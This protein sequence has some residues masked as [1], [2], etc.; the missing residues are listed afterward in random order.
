MNEI[1]ENNFQEVVNSV[2]QEV[3]SIN[4]TNIESFTKE[5][6]DYLID[7]II[8]KGYILNSKS[9]NYLRGNIKVVISSLRKNLDNIEYASK[10]VKNSEEIFNYFREN[11]L[12]YFKYILKKKKISEVIDYR[13]FNLCLDSL[14]NYRNDDK[15]FQTRVNQLVIN[16]V[17]TYPKVSTFKGIFDSIARNRWKEFRLEFAIDFENIFG[18]ICS[19]LRDTSN[20]K[21]A[22]NKMNFLE[23]MERILKDKY[24]LLYDDMKKYFNIY[25]SD[26]NIDRLKPYQ[27]EISKLSALYVAIA[28]EDFVK[29]EI[30]DYYYLIKQ[31]FKLK[32]D[33][34]L[35]K[36]QI[37]EKKRWEKIRNLYEDDMSFKEYLNSIVNKYNIY[38]SNEILNNLINEFINNKLTNLEDIIS[39]P[40]GYYD[41]IRYNK[42]KKLI[43]RLNRGYIKYDDQEVINYQDLIKFNKKYEYIGK[44][45]SEKDIEVYEEYQKKIKVFDNI[46]KEITHYID[47]LGYDNNYEEILDELSKKFPFTDEYF[48]F[49]SKTLNLF[50]LNTLYDSLLFNTCNFNQ[51]SFINDDDYSLLSEIFINNG[52]IWLLMFLS[53]S[54]QPITNDFNGNAVLNYINNIP[55]IY[56]LVL[57]T[58]YSNST[59]NDFSKL[60][61]IVEFIT[62]QDIAILGY[63][64]VQV[65]CKSTDY[66]DGDIKRIMESAVYLA[67]EK[68]KRTKLTVPFINGE[69]LDYKYSLYD[70][71]ENDEFI[72]GPLTDSCLKVCGNDHD[73]LTYCCLNKNGFMV[74]ITDREGNFIGRAAGVRNG[75]S[76]FFNQLRTIYDEGISYEGLNDSEK[77]SIIETFKKIC[78]DL[79]KNSYEC[80]NDIVKIEHVFVTRSFCLSKYP[81]N[82]SKEVIKKIGCNPI[83]NS[84]CDWQF[85]INNTK[86][87]EYA[88]RDNFIETDYGNYPVIC[89][90][91]IKDISNIDASDIKFMDVDAVYE[92]IRN[93]VIVTRVNEEVINKI[94]KIHGINTY[95]S[96]REF[97]YL[98]IPNESMVIMGDNWYIVFNNKIIDECVLNFDEKAIK[99]FNKIKEELSKNDIKKLIRS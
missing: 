74:K 15:K 79:I 20:F 11:N 30:E 70:F 2:L 29:S 34:P 71:L 51:D 39:A 8:S 65:L 23:H 22:L 26:N 68:V 85:F 76:I 4:Y 82:L 42:V 7:L 5:E 66:T 52:I 46:K 1:I 67:S 21:R 17:I 48:T 62:K 25:H 83:D 24:N 92:R 94:N 87:L 40:I 99:E 61:D 43:N 3:N 56:E 35:I 18:K 97:T 27:D 41:Y 84:S 95:L 93:K 14:I 69:Y 9:S 55:K 31:Y 81:K 88:R 38:M 91:S 6:Q 54:V 50:D 10:D 80:N 78:N 86:Y 89:M 63:N 33:N 59:F 90:A 53:N 12:T 75:N 44:I 98:K 32:I 77:N 28:K 37:I 16:S 47:S 19:I 73:L 57:N 72:S 64:N 58:N 96:N 60:N 49:D 45:F 36:K 13:I